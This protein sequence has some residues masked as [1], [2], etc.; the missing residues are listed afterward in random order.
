M[1]IRWDLASSDS[2][3]PVCFSPAAWGLSLNC[4]QI[5]RSTHCILLYFS[6][7]FILFFLWVLS[8]T[9]V[10]LVTMFSLL[11]SGVLALRDVVLWF[12]WDR[13]IRTAVLLA[14][15]LWRKRTWALQCGFQSYSGLGVCP[16]VLWEDECWGPSCLSLPSSVSTSLS[17]IPSPY[18]PAISFFCSIKFA[19]VHLYFHIVF[20]LIIWV[21]LKHRTTIKLGHKFPH[22]QR[23]PRRPPSHYG[24][25]AIDDVF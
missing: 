1:A 16:D 11:I 23:I 22:S 15:F 21:T 8:G 9:W 19:L 20:L 7:Q 3:Y 17:F 18:S 2:S 25:D 24:W 6:Y 5:T 4:P 14:S 13:V 10:G 12:K